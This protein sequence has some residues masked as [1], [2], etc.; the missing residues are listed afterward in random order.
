M[1]E[2]PDERLDLRGLKC[3]QPVLRTRKHLRSMQ[4]GGC[5]IVE[6]T[7]P[8]AVIDLPNLVREM[9]AVL[10]ATEQGEGFLIFRIRKGRARDGIESANRAAVRLDV[11]QRRAVDAIEAA[12]DQ[13]RPLPP[14]EADG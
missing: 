2:P 9:G 11:D 4:A 7:D 3:P 12:D 13:H 8:L 1:S 10:L 5:V 14:D 6:C